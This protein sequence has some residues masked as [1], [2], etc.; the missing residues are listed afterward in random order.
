M[1]SARGLTVRYPGAESPALADVDLDVLCG[2]LVALTGPNGSGK[3]TLVRAILGLVKPAHGDALV[4]GRS[5]RAWDRRELARAV[6]VV[7]QREEVLFPLRVREM[8]MMG[9]Y[10]H[11]GA[12]GAEREVDRVAVHDALARCDVADLADRRVDTLSGGEWQRVRVARALAQEPRALV[13]DEPTASLDVRHE[14]EIFELV[15]KLATSGLAAL[16][17]THQLNLASRYAE[18]VLLL[19]Q[20]RVA[21]LGPPLEV[22]T[23]EIVSGTFR[24]PTTVALGHDG[25]PQVTPLRPGDHLAATFP[26]PGHGR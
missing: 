11:L 15:R 23:R 13:L 10:A 17:V 8:V 6:G 4:D 25:A 20:G 3:T 18:R 14:M 26:T 1:L 2:E 9:R 19:D 16:V 24:W 7:T 21:A 22:L 12:L 5:A